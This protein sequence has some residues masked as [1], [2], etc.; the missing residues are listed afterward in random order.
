M[1]K[2]PNCGNE[3]QNQFCSI[4][5]EK[6]TPTNQTQPGTSSNSTPPEPQYSAPPQPQYTHPFP[7]PPSDTSVMSVGDWLV[8]LLLMLIPCVNIIMLIIWAASSTGNANRRNWA[9]AYLIFFAII[10]A[11]YL[12]LVLIFGFAMFSIFAW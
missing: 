4:C 3:S 12:L 9:R 11:I 1:N 10:F 2:C 6:T 8:T 5:G 7:P